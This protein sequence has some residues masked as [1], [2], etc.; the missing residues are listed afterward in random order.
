MRSYRQDED[1][2]KL[3]QQ[4]VKESTIGQIAVGVPHG[5]Y[6]SIKGIA[7]LGGALSDLYLDTETLDNVQKALPE[8]DLNDI[9]GDDAGGVAKFTS[10][11]TQYGTGFGLAQKIAKKLFG[12]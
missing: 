10:L 2:G 8:I 4:K 11:L 5:I 3:A 6:T 12:N 9:Y 1:G 7:E